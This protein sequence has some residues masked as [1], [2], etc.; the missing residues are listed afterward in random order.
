MAV[1]DLLVGFLLDGE[2]RGDAFLGEG[3]DCVMGFYVMVDCFGGGFQGGGCELV[4]WD[5]GCEEVGQ[6]IGLG[7]VG[8]CF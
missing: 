6:D 4:S 7:K 5:G 8:E 1:V 2:E 3:A